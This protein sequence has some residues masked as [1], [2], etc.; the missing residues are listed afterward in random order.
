QLRNMA[1]TG[2]TLMQRT[3]C[4]Y[5]RDLAAACNK[6]APG[7]GCDAISGYNRGHAVLGG[8]DSCIA[9]HPSDMSVA[10]VALDA[11]ARTRRPDGSTRRVPVGELFLL[12]GDTPERETV[13]EHGELITHVDLP[14]LA[15][16]RR[17]HYLKVRDRASYE[18]AL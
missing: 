2:G 3:R 14:H 17:S 1:T 12:P 18:F 11:V 6:R 15:F 8:S 5:F 13:L 7:S 9:T 10:L 4:P 16:G